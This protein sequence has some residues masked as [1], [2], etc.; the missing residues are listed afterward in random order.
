MLPAMSSRGVFDPKIANP[1]NADPA[2][3]IVLS[4]VCQ[5]VASGC[6]EWVLLD[7]GDIEL[8][9]NTGETYLLAQRVI[10]RVA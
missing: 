2:K 6:G 8:S 1:F 7:N 9:F 10:I 3:T 4:Y 5:L